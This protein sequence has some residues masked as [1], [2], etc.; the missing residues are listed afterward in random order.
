MGCLSLTVDDV[1]VLAETF[2]IW[3]ALG[4]FFGLLWYDFMCWFV[5]S[6]FRR[7]SSRAS[8]EAPKG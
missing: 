4:V 5:L 6:A 3:S 8:D 7:F 1:S 2:M